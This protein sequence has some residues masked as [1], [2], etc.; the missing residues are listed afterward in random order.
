MWISLFLL[1]ALRPSGPAPGQKIA[2]AIGISLCVAAFLIVVFVRAAFSNKKHHNIRATE[3]S[4]VA[5]QLG[6]SYIGK[7]PIPDF[8]TNSG[9]PMFTGNH[10][11][12]SGTGTSKLELTHLLQGQVNGLHVSLFDFTY[13]NK[14]SMGMSGKGEY[15]LQTV[16]CIPQTPHPPFLFYRAKQLVAGEHVRAFLDE[17]LRAFSQRR[18]P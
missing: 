13:F 12:V 15:L 10:S 17:A 4:T 11:Y 14:H 1:L 2:V 16:V 3:L 9:D 5:Q 18:H 6:F 7:S 8:L